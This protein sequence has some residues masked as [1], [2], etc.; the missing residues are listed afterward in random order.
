M[1]KQS[2][3]DKENFD[4]YAVDYDAALAHGLH[5]SGEDKIYFAKGRIA[6]LAGCLRRLKEQPRSVMDLGCGTGS[7]EPFLLDLMGVESVLGVDTSAKS[8]EIAQQTCGSKHAQFLP[9]NQYQPSEQFDLVFCNGV[10]HHIPPHERAETV[11]LVYRSL[12][13]GGLFAVW[14]NNPWNPGARYVMSRIPFD[15]DAVMLTPA[16][17]RRMLRAG[18]FKILRT[19]FLFI[20]PRMLAWLR[21]VEPF[22]SRLPFG[23]Q[24]QVLCLKR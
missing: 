14:E 13:S 8:L 1:T 10:F 6:W 16:E 19:D 7:A 21:G 3:L 24:Y 20:F 23:A 5:V 18:H 9:L 11:D 4:Q 15:R 12:R 2:H 17:T 22:F